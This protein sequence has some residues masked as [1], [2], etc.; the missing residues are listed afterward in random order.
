MWRLLAAVGS[1]LALI[2][3]ACGG[4][5]SASQTGGTTG[6]ERA[7]AADRG[8]V[9]KLRASGALGP[10]YDTSRLRIARRKD[11]FIFLA[12]PG[13]GLSRGSWCLIV[14]DEKAPT[15]RVTTFCGERAVLRSDDVFFTVGSAG[16]GDAGVP[17]YGIAVDGVARVRSG[18]SSSNVVNNVFS[19]AVDGDEGELTLI[20]EDGTERAFDISGEI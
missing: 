18:D 3:L 12:A 7:P 11:G 10:D 5:D 13:R 6:L 17:I 20:Y 9:A 16:E 15:V 14:S 19:L 4:E 2:P 1:S 8:L